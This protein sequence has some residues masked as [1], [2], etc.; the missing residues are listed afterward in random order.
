MRYEFESKVF[1]FRF[2]RFSSSYRVEV[3]F[4]RV[5]GFSFVRAEREAF[6]VSWKGGSCFRP[7]PRVYFGFYAWS[8]FRN[9]V[10]NRAYNPEVADIGGKW[11]EKFDG[12]VN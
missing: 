6:G 3:C 11:A 9:W 12:A 1:C 7:V 8:V 2:N 10:K 5:F 4:P